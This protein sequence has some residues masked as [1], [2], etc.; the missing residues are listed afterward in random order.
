MLTVD[1]SCSFR[2]HDAFVNAR[3]GVGRRRLSPRNGGWVADHFLVACDGEPRS[4]EWLERF[5]RKRFQQRQ[6]SVVRMLAN[7]VL[8]EHLL[9][10][11]IVRTGVLAVQDHRW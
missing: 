6:L 3:V 7:E 5:A 8:A 10:A 4:A 2:V 1:V 9:L 11:L